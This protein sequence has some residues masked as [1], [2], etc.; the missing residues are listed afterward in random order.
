MKAITLFPYRRVGVVGRTGSNVADACSYQVAGQPPLAGVALP[1]ALIPSYQEWLTSG[2]RDIL[3]Q[4]THWGEVLDGDCHMLVREARRM[5][6]GFTGRL[7]IRGPKESLPL[8][9]RG[10][11]V[12][13]PI[14]SRLCHVLELGAELGASQIIVHSPFPGYD[15]ARGARSEAAGPEQVEAVRAALE[16]VLRLARDANLTLVIENRYDLNPALLL[17]LVR[18]FASDH[19]RMGLDVRL[20][21][22]AQR[23]GGPP[24]AEWVRAAGDHLAHVMLQDC[25]EPG[26]FHRG[27]AGSPD[28]FDLFDALGKLGHCPRL[29]I[30][31]AGCNDSAEATGWLAQRGLV[32]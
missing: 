21:S 24:A 29:M 27:H 6:D 4:E 31:A 2:Q 13:M 17:A 25:G 18:S 22:I 16:P 14:T 15:E 5:L 7:C 26:R 9:R 20:A 30:Q 28:W 11:Q 19:I 8:L 23:A 12:Y 32:R 3:I 1:I 10:L